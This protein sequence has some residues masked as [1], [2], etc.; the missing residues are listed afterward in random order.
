MVLLYIMIQFPLLIHFSW[1]VSFKA[2]VTV[3]NLDSFRYR[4]TV[5][6]SDSFRWRVTICPPDSF[7]IPIT[8]SI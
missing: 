5:L 7:P 4:V 8:T 2:T 1:H 6:Y 3:I